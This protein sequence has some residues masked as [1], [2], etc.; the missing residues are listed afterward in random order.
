MTAQDAIAFILVGLAALALAWR[1]FRATLGP[2]TA[3]WLFRHGHF[4]LG[5]RLLP[6]SA[7]GHCVNAAPRT[8]LPDARPR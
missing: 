3:R 1:F 7:C 5:R 4:T 8:I 6:T 2:R